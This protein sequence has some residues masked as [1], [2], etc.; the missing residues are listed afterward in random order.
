MLKALALSS[1]LLM[2]GV[3]INRGVLVDTLTESLTR[4]APTL[5]TEGEPL[6]NVYS[7]RIILCANSGQTLSGGGTLQMWHYNTSTGWARNSGLDLTVTA[8]SVRCQAF[9]DVLVGPPYGRFLAAPNAVTV[10][11]GT[12]PTVRYEM[13]IR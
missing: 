4:S 7:Y 3:T 11:G 5:S 8:T 13:E 10:S 1:F 6:D 12:T 2:G 9:P